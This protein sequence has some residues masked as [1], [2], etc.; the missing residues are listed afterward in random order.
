M[1]NAREA[2]ATILDCV[3]PLEAITIS[4]EQSLGRVLAEDI[5]SLENIPPFDNAGMDGFAVRSE[6]IKSIPSKLNIVGE[7]PAGSIAMKSIGG[8]E[9]M[10]IMT[11]AKIPEGA[12]AV[13]QV[14]WTEKIDDM[15]V[16]ILHRVEAGHNI[17][18][19]GLDVQKGSV[20]LS[21]GQ[22]LRPQHVGL[23]ASAG[24]RFFEVYRPA[25][26][27][28]LATGNEL[29]ELDK[30]LT[31][32]KIRNSNAYALLALV[33][34]AGCEPLNLGVAKDDHEK[35]RKKVIEGLAAD[36]LITSG[37]VSVGKYDLVMDIMKEVGVEIKFWKV[38][39]KPGMPLVFGLYKGKPVFGLPG[40]PVSTVITFLKFVKPALLKMTGHQHPEEA[41]KLRAI[42]ES[43]L[44]KSDGKRHFVRGILESRNG[45]MI[46]R[47]A[48]SQVSNILT[49]VA[50]ANCLIILPEEL[51]VA[52]VGEEVEL[53]LL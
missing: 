51:Q 15:H 20:L 53:E 35:I 46:V 36:V 52:R 44:T 30:P 33:T 41:L 40:N 42:L 45:S 12:T 4:L 43:E 13:V 7:I 11:G 47:T 49:S 2:I 25:E 34:E 48:G 29:V 38:N 16:S 19:A 10:S 24:K 21:T 6:D 8:G 27:A 28:I 31:E 22:R 1:I 18:K 26:V 50:K 17:R 23:L 14:E 5:V 3:R 39:I 32:G 9:A 37:G